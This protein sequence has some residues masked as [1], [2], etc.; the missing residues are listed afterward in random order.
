[1]LTS[2][3]MMVHVGDFAL[4]GSERFS[5]TAPIA[6]FGNFQEEFFDRLQQ[7]AVVVL[8]INDFRARNQ[9]FVAFAPHLLDENGDLH[10]AAAAD[11]ENFRIVG[12]R[13]AQ[14]RRSCGFP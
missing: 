11:V 14:A 8:A 7:V 12:L 2:S 5:I 1:M 3:P 10:F 6:S 13:D 4:C 9:N